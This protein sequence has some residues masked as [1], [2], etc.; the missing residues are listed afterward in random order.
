MKAEHRFIRELEGKT[1]QYVTCE[2][3][4]RNATYM[5][6]FADGSHITVRGDGMQEQSRFVDSKPATP[7]AEGQQG[8]R[9]I[10]DIHARIEEVC[11]AETQARAMIERRTDYAHQRISA[12]EQ[13]FEA[14][15]KDFNGSCAQTNTA[16][17]NIS[18]DVANMRLSFA[19]RHDDSNVLLSEFTRR[20]GAIES[21]L[22]SFHRHGE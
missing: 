3:T 18:K 2:A 10:E 13:R 7:Q 16:L 12:L 14:L 11:D 22:N 15:T 20:I 1:V 4:E 8:S 17:A 9:D 19:R 6:V 21:F 5:F